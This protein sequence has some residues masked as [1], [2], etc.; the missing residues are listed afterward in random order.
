MSW[1]AA[2]WGP[3]S[4]GADGPDPAPIATPFTVLGSN[5]AKTQFV[6]SE[7]LRLVFFPFF[8]KVNNEYVVAGTD[9]ATVV[10]KKPNGTLL[11]PAP[12][13]V[14]DTDTNFW[15]VEIAVGDY[16]EGDWQVKATSDAADTLPQYR[17]FT[18]GDYVDE[19]PIL[20]ALGVGRWKVN[21]ATDR[22][23]LYAA[24]GLTILYEFDLKDAAG[25]PNSSVVFERVPVP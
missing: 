14:F 22:L 17:I 20:K 19:L 11:T 16:M 7:P 24:D 3:T 6:S 10:V 23:E 13:L 12:T 9:V 2:A 4:F 8:D 1:G 25:L 21:T 5:M 18:W 15:V